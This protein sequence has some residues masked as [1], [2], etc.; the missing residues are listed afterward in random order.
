M[1]PISLPR[2]LK[3]GTIILASTQGHGFTSLTTRQKIATTNR[4][5]FVYIISTR[6]RF[7]FC[8]LFLEQVCCKKREKK[9]LTSYWFA[10]LATSEGA[11]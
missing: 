1:L 4:Y 2:W 5:V 10:K 8:S 9:Y 7:W 6:A 3:R 11:E